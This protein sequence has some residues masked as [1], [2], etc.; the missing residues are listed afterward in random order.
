M[1]QREKYNNKQ[2]R[3]CEL[4]EYYGLTQ[5][6]LADKIGISKSML[7]FIETGKRIPNVY[8]GMDIA[9]ALSTT[10]EELFGRKNSVQ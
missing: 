1:V 9:Q 8:I 4:R 6:K 3:V 10:V 5:Q 2:N 7:S